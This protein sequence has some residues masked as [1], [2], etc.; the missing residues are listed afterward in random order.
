MLQ[1]LYYL[2]VPKIQSE[3]LVLKRSK[4][5]VTKPKSVHFQQPRRNSLFSSQK[6]AKWDQSSSNLRQYKSRLK[7]SRP[8]S[9]FTVAIKVLTQDIQIVK[10]NSFSSKQKFWLHFDCVI[11]GKLCFVDSNQTHRGENQL[12]IGTTKKCVLKQR[13]KLNYL[14]IGEMIV[15]KGKTCQ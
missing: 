4:L 8:T 1:K 3:V 15:K 2:L 9:Q 11:Y 14:Q 5:I 12:Q 6:L 7:Y 10:I 13:C